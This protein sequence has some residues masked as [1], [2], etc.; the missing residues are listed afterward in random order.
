[1]KVIR[2]ITK[3]YQELIDAENVEDVLATICRHGG[4]IVAN[5]SVRKNEKV[6]SYAEIYFEEYRNDSEE[7]IIG[8]IIYRNKGSL[9]FSG[10]C[11]EIPSFVLPKEK[12]QLINEV[13]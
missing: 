6:L 11:N 2:Q 1:M 3:L 4:Y 10:N 9:F 5:Y 12:V 13:F 8:H 7:Y